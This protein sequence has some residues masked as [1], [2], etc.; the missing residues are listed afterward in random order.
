MAYQAGQ[1][2]QGA[3]E[4]ASRATYQEIADRFRVKERV[5]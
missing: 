2:R 4:A 5:V 3:G 1:V